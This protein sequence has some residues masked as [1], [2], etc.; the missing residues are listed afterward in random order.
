MLESEIMIMNINHHIW[1]DQNSKHINVHGGCVLFHEG[2]YYWYGESYRWE[3]KTKTALGVGVY[4]STDLSSWR[5]HGMA[6]STMDDIHH[7]LAHG[8][9]VQRPHVLYNKKNNNFVMWFHHE[10]L[11]DLSGYRSAASAV[12]ISDSPLGPFEFISSNR[13]NAGAYPQN[14]SD[15]WN[16]KLSDRERDLLNKLSFPGGEVKGQYYP[17]NLLYRRDLEGGQMARDMSLFLD[18]DGMAYHVYSSEENGTLHISQLNDDFTASIGK[19]VRIFPGRFHEAPNICKHHGRYWLLSSGCT[20]WAPNPARSAVAD[21]IWGPWTEL[22]NPI[23][24][25]NPNNDLGAEKTFGAQSSCIFSIQKHDDTK[26]VA[27][28]DVWRPQNHTDGRYLWLEMSFHQNH[29]EIQ[30]QNALEV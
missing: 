3:K 15:L 8:C 5:D 24:G 27:M 30:W 29:Y 18:D 12:A 2:N 7:P 19:Y 25:V 17:E 13:H 4:S 16:V 22:N 23:K 9:I 6:I 20:S 1:P 14:N 28:F 26:H 21:S 10:R 11:E